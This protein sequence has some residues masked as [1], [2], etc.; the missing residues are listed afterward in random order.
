MLAG[1]VQS[2]A[3]TRVDF[4]SACGTTEVVPFQSIDFFRSP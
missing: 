3:K 2:W 4:A 1:R